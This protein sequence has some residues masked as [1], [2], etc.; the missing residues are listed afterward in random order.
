MVPNGLTLFWDCTAS[1]LTT[2]MLH[3][4]G[5]GLARFV[6][7][8]ALKGFPSPA[9][10]IAHNFGAKV[11]DDKSPAATPDDKVWVQQVNGYFLYYARIQNTLILPACNDISAKQ[12]NP[13]ANTVKAI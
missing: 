3:Y 12:A 8:L 10:Y 13:T 11:T 6:P 9:A 5:K 1:T 2:S 7:G 4:V